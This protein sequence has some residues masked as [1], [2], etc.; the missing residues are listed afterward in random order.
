MHNLIKNASFIL[1]DECLVSEDLSSSVQEKPNS[2]SEIILDAIT[3]NAKDQIFIFDLEKEN[4]GM[5]AEKITF[6]LISKACQSGNCHI[7]LNGFRVFK[8]V[9]VLKTDKNGMVE[10]RL[11]DQLGDPEDDKS[12]L[13]VNVSTIKARFKGKAPIFIFAKVVNEIQQS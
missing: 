3:L 9:D 8:V 4:E 13:N 10:V 1:D 12:K 11:V 2:N 6:E 7:A 5:K